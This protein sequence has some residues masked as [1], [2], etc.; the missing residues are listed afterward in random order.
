M[1]DDNQLCVRIKLEGFFE[2]CRI[3]IPGVLFRV[4]EDGLTVFVGDRI[5]GGVEGHVAGKDRV[6]FKC[7]FIRSRLAVKSFTGKLG[8]QM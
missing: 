1:G 5:D 4:D 6:A 7:T 2:R 8:C 3:H